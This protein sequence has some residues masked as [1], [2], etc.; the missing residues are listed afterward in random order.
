MDLIYQR[1]RWTADETREFVWDTVTDLFWHAEVHHEW[2]GEWYLWNVLTRHGPT[3]QW[4]YY[5]WWYG[6][7]ELDERFSSASSDGD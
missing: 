4:E 1:F 6:L 2:Y 7:W 5:V 3:W